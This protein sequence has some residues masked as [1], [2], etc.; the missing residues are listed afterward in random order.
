MILTNVRD[1]ESYPKIS[2][3][4]FNS[5]VRCT[6]QHDYLYNQKLRKTSTSS[7][8]TK[9]SYLHGLMERYIRDPKGFNLSKSAEEVKLELVQERGESVLEDDAMSIETLFSA[10]IA[11]T[12]PPKA[13]G[14]IEDEPLVEQEF[15]VDIGLRNLEGSPVLFHGFIDA[16]VMEDTSVV[17]MEHKTASRA[18]SEAQLQQNYQGPLY[19]HTLEILTGLTVD[20]VRFNFFYPKTFASRSLYPT[21]EHKASLVRE[22]QAAVYLR[23]TGSIVKSPH[24]S[25]SSCPMQQY[26][27]LETQGMDA[28]RLI[29][30]TYRVD[31]AEEDEGS[32]D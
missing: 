7:Y 19:A 16:V 14:Y 4:E 21:P 31:N 32:E 11:K 2:I 26:C 12:K 20:E 17:V 3:T 1:Y 25:C 9:G 18:W 15:Y 30:V 24:W 27:I 13:L 5:L 23:D 10:Y 29:G 8:L 6:Q 22:L 28:S